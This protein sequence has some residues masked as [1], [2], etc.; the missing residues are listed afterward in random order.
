MQLHEEI[1]HQYLSK[2]KY[3]KA[4]HTMVDA[5]QEPMYWLVRKIVFKHEDAQDVVQNAFVKVWNHIQNADGSKSIKSWLLTIAYN[6]AID[7]WRKS[8][9]RELTGLEILE[10]VQ[11]DAYVDFEIMEAAFKKAILLLPEQQRIIFNL[12]YFDDLGH[13]EIATMLKLSEGGVKSSYHHAVKKIKSALNL[14][15]D[16]S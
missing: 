9:K 8:Q 16:E 3:R 12:K 4:F 10:F 5:Y 11:Q 2:K 14:L 15:N 7:A 6:E 1:I 13:K